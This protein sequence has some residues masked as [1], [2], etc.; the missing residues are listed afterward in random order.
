MQSPVG[1]PQRPRAQT[2]S[3]PDCGGT[4][5]VDPLQEKAFCPYCHGATEVPPSLRASA[6]GYQWELGAVRAR[7]QGELAQ[8]ETILGGA[9]RHRSNANLTAMVL[10]GSGLAIP[11]SFLFTLA[12]SAGSLALSALLE[13]FLSEG[14]RLTAERWSPVLLG[15]LLLA[16][17]LGV[18][19]LVKNRARAKRDAILS[20]LQNCAGALYSS[21]S[22]GPGEALCAEC[23]G[24]VNFRTGEQSTRCPHCH[25]TVL[26]SGQ[27]RRGLVSFAIRE[28][29]LVSKLIHARVER[30]RVRAEQ[31]AKHNQLWLWLMVVGGAGCVVPALLLVGLFTFS[32][33]KLRHGVEDRLSDFAV[34]VGSKLA[35]GLDVPFDWL[36]AY[37]A[38][39]APEQA[40]SPTGRLGLRWSVHTRFCGRP[41]LVTATSD[42]RDQTADRMAVLLAHPALR[43]AQQ[44]ASGQGSPAAQ[45]AAQLG[46]EIELTDAGVALLGRELPAERIGLRELRQL[47]ACAHAMTEGIGPAR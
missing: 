36:D 47:V 42:W 15:L 14:S 5:P 23:G 32:V 31:Q 2:I 3:C 13:P 16:L 46:F 35:R 44:S 25:Q 9:Q 40:W 6:L 7:G 12:V 1:E 37:W 10:L 17:S 11:V 22:G 4:L 18:V 19:R 29:H 43:S 8:A 34:S 45:T 20:A 39:T 33:R 21:G 27:Q 38:G 30:E 28:A 26:P 41:V 24:L